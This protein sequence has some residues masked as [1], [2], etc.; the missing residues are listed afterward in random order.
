MCACNI[1]PAEQQRM[2]NDLANKLHQAQQNLIVL[3][4][5]MV[6]LQ[7]LEAG[8]ASQSAALYKEIMKDNT[9]DRVSYLYRIL[10]K[11]TSA[12]F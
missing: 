4:K 10:N 11:L 6:K 7:R 12:A 5:Q 2:K 1:S 3:Q 9:L 8:K